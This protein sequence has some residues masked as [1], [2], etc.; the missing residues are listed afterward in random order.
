MAAQIYQFIC[1]KDNFGVLIHDPHTR[2]TASIDAPEAAPILAALDARGWRLTD[3]LITHHHADH[4]QGIAGLKAKFPGARV[5]GPRAEASKIG[6]LDYEVGE[7]DSVKV[8]ALEAVVIEAPGHT[9]GHV[10]YWF[11]DEDIAFAGDTLFAMGCGRPFEEPPQVLF[12]SLMK[13]AA[14]PGETQVY[15]GH[16]Y[17]LANAR[18]ALSVDPGNVILQER[19]AEVAQLRADGKFTLPTTISIE[20]A[21]NPFLRADEPEVKAAVG[22]SGADPVSVFAEL[23]ERK[24]RA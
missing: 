17:T 23:R 11:E 19:A 24:N 1:L 21:T 3:I 16:E 10:A 20:L 13:L 2:A 4:V 18:F 22:M 6:G 7:G 8:G 12:H 9:A 15:C 14:L 5:T